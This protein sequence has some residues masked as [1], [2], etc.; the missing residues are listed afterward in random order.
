[1]RSLPV[2]LFLGIFFSAALAFAAPKG[3]GKKTKQKTPDIATVEITC[4]VPN[5]KVLIDDREVAVT[6]LEEPLEVEPGKHT[7]KV[8][9]PGYAPF[10]D[11]FT[12]VLGEN[13]PIS[14]DL[15]PIAGYLR[16]SL[17]QEDEEKAQVYLDG[18]YLG[19]TPY[20]GEISLGPHELEVRRLGSKDFRRNFSA[21]G[22]EEYPFII[23]MEV[24]PDELN[25]L[26]DKGRAALPPLYKRPAVQIGGGS[27]LSV[28]L[29]GVV[30]G[31]ARGI[32]ASQGCDGLGCRNDEDRALPLP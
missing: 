21:V 4:H 27:A 7:I 6:P 23:E 10:A 2:V 20:E 8:V 19:D 28:L 26:V 22:G 3:K 12:A 16:V 11:V 5:A 24:F 17:S 1:M 31:I 29:G 9:K 13:V 25:P 30:L 15:F 18:T 14:V 32:A